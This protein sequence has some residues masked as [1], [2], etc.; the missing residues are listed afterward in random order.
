LII[1]YGFSDSGIRIAQLTLG[2]LLEALRANPGPRMSSAPRP[3]DRG[4]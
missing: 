2:D 3:F 4:G 1:P